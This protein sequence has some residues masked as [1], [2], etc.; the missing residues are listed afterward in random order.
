M[1]SSFFPLNLFKRNAD[2]PPATIPVPGALLDSI[3]EIC[4]RAISADFSGRIDPDLADARTL[5]AVEAFNAM[6]D[7]AAG[8]IARRDQALQD[9]VEVV[10]RVARGQFEPR[11]TRIDPLHPASEL[12]H[13][14]NDLVD[15]VDAFT[16]EAAASLDAVSHNVYYRKIFT[17]GLGGEFLRA[18]QSINNVSTAMGERVAG[19]TSLTGRLAENVSHMADAIAA[20][21][22]SVSEVSGVADDTSERSVTVAA[23]A[24]ETTASLE[25]IASAAEEMLSSIGEINRRVTHSAEIAGSAI[26]EVVDSQ[27]VVRQL[28]G[29]AA[30][31][32]EVLNLIGDIASQTNLLALNAT[33]EAARAGDAGKGFAVVASEVKSLATQ[34]ARATEDIARQVTAMQQATD[35]TVGTIGTIGKT[36]GEI[37]EICGAIASAMTEQEATTREISANIQTAAAGSRDVSRNMGEVSD[38]ADRSRESARSLSETMEAL[39][40]RSDSLVAEATAFLEASKATGTD[41]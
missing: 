1:T 24:E 7:K 9:A 18:A 21:G 38:G 4:T 29:A 37:D 5:P 13:A 33:I 41:G 10:R 31:I 25:S 17:T 6:L 26:R 20:M 8:R 30:S 14:L 27:E 12:M 34:T 3:A 15:V 19:F 40:H 2:T 11:L 39:K 35:A 28:S 22:E 23:A 16:R 36:V 32:N